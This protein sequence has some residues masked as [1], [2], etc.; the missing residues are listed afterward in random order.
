MKRVYIDS[1]L[2][3]HRNLGGCPPSVNGVL[4]NRTA[5]RLYGPVREQVRERAWAI[6]SGAIPD[7]VLARPN[8]QVNP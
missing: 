3:H 2:V 7:I 8:P 1:P 4:W 6:V 5:D